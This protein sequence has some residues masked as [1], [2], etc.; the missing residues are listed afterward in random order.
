M[1]DIAFSS[2]FMKE[3]EAYPVDTGVVEVPN[4]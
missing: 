1:I 2:F 3:T 4:E